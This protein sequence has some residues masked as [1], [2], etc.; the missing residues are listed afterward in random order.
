MAESL[1]RAVFNLELDDSAFQAG[2]KNAQRGVGTVVDSAGRLRDEFG[3]YVKQQ[4]LATQGLTRFNQESSRSGI[5]NLTAQ[6]KGLALQLGGLGI[7]TAAF[8]QI[9]QADDAAAAVRTLGVDSVQLSNNLQLLS[10]SLRANVST[11]ELTK[12][13]YDVASAGFNNAADATKVLEAA[14]LGAKGGFSTITTVSDAATSVLNAYGLAADQATKIV[15]GFITTQNDGKI[16][17]NQYAQQIGKIAPIAAAA[18]VGIDELN[19]A[20]SAATAQGVPV[21]STFSGLRQALASILKPTQEAQQLANKLGIEFNAT[22]LATQGFGQFLQQVAKATNGSAEANSTLFGSVEA[23]AAIQPLLNDQLVKYTQSLNNQRNS[24]GAAAS[25]ASIVSETISSGIAAIGN[26]FSN[27]ATSTSFSTIG[28]SLAGIA[29]TINSISLTPAQQQ[30]T[31]IESS[32]KIVTAEIKR[33]KEYG[34]DTTVADRRLKELESRAIRLKQIVGEQTEIESLKGQAVELGKQA[35][36]LKRAGQDARVLNGQLGTI[37]NEIAAL[38]GRSI[39]FNLP[40][41]TQITGEINESLRALGSELDEAQKKLGSL[42]KQRSLAAPGID[43]TE[44]D[45]SVLKAQQSVDGIRARIKIEAES[46]ALDS[47]IKRIKGELRDPRL[48][49]SLFGPQAKKQLNESLVDL[50][51]QREVLSKSAAETQKQAQAAAAVA[52]NQATAAKQSQAQAKAAALGASQALQ[53]EQDQRNS[54]LAS[55]TIDAQQLKSQEARLGLYAQETQLVGQINT[56]RAQGAIA[57]SDTIKSLLDQE[58]AQAQKLASTDGQRRQLELQYGQA[59]FNQTVA[60]FDLKAIALGTEQQAQRASLAFEQQKAAAAG[61]RAEIEAQIALLQAQAA[62]A[63]KGTAESQRQVEL[64]K[65]NLDLI[66]EQNSQEQALGGLR[67]QLLDEQQAAAR[68]QLEQQRLLALN[69]QAENGTL[70]QQRQLQAD[71]NQELK[72]RAGYADAAAVSASNFREQLQGAAQA[73]G[74]LSTAFQAQVNTV[75]DGSQQFSQMNT[76]LSQI[77]TNTSK[78]PT[79]NVTVNNSAAG[80]GNSSAAVVS[81]TSR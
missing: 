12:A 49:L 42:E 16:V 3:R 47:E 73:R 59:K 52:K 68:Q 45:R 28:T 9:R 80:R 39:S 76:F 34:L 65:E 54:R 14:A 79:V 40:D 41:G 36:A 25:A 57:R 44:L 32:I 61:K 63:D 18:G 37:G 26:A 72:N 15:D 38:E 62:N 56:V 58:L 48:S 71:V 33:R 13:A 2:L 31:A 69:G 30:L 10:G 60:E 11:L 20:I 7:A 78:P 4:D 46:K 77:A 8:N 70:E 17:V 55:L 6:V 50:E 1:G 35:E 29:E 74:D 24:A 75:I 53:S 51:Q 67:S 66:R 43:T 19:A 22:A 5:Q 21:E 64:A 81:G 27:L 23:L